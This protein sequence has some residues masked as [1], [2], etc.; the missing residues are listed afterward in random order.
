M[1]WSVESFGSP[2]LILFF[3]S[4]ISVISWRFF[5]EMNSALD[6][7]FICVSY[8]IELDAELFLRLLF[9]F[10]GITAILVVSFDDKN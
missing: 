6:L 5:D 1:K 3:L 9:F 8:E 4:G 7:S 10:G 2:V